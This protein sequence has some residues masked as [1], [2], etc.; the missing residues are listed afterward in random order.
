MQYE[1]V[2]PG[3]L[4]WVA[5]D[6]TNDTL[7]IIGSQIIL[8][9]KFGYILTIFD[10]T[11]YD[12]LRD[13]ILPQSGQS[14][15]YIIVEDTT[16][17]VEPGDLIWTDYDGTPA[18]TPDVEKM[19]LVSWGGYYYSGFYYITSTGMSGFKLGDKLFLDKTD[20]SQSP[21]LWTYVEKEPI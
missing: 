1:V 13:K 19:L 2:K 16:E 9:W 21:I 18:T 8:F 15:A 10:G 7:P 6:G 17:Y 12:G 3:D 4:T 14:W 5:Y 20:I 11:H